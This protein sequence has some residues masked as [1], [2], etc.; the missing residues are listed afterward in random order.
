MKRPFLSMLVISLLLVFAAYAWAG[1]GD[2]DPTFGNQGLVIQND[3]RELDALVLQTDGKVVAVGTARS[4]G[5]ALARYNADGSLDATFGSGGVVI[6]PQIGAGLRLVLQPDGKLVAG[7]IAW[8]DSVTTNFALA[9]YNPDGSLD[10]TFGSGGI[11]ILPYST[12]GDF[13][14]ALALAPDGK[15]VAVGYSNILKQP[16]GKSPYY[17]EQILLARINA[18]GTLDQSFGTVGWVTKHP[19]DFDYGM[20]ATVQPDNKIIVGAFSCKDTELTYCTGLVLRYQ[21]DG[22]A[23]LSFGRRGVAEV[24]TGM[25][26]SS[27]G[28]V[29]L[30]ADGK[31]VGQ[32]GPAGPAGG[33]HVTRFNAD[34]SLD[35]TFGSGGV[36]VALKNFGAQ[37]MIARADGSLLLAGHSFPQVFDGSADFALMSFTEAGTV[38]PQFGNDGLAARH[39]SSYDM[40]NALVV[41]PDNKIVAAGLFTGS[42]GEGFIAVLAR[43]VDGKC[44][45]GTLEAGED[46]DDGNLTDGDGCDSNCTL[47]RC[48]NGIASSGE[49]C[50]DGNGQNADACKN[51]CTLNVC[52]DGVVRTG[53]EICDDGNAVDDD[54]CSNSC[55]RTRC[56]D[57][58]KDPSEECD[59]GNAVNGDGCD[60]NCLT[61]H[62]GNGR[63]EGGEQC[64][65][66]SASGD[67]NCA[68]DCHW[69]LQY[70]AVLRPVNPLTVKLGPGRDEITRYLT[71][72]LDAGGGHQAPDR[73]VAQLTASNGDCPAGTI[74]EST[75]PV[76][77][78]A[79]VARVFI[80]V[81][82]AA[83]PNATADTPQRC[84]LR[85]TARIYP[86][87]VYDPNPENNSV[88]V[89][90]NVLDLSHPQTAQSAS[91]SLQSVKPLRAQIARGVTTATKTVRLS[92]TTKAP[93]PTQTIT[94][95]VSDGTCPK[96]TVGQPAPSAFTLARK[97]R[98]VSLPLALSSTAF[99]SRSR[100]SPSR[101]TATVTATLGNG[102]AQTVQLVVD[103][104]DG[105]DL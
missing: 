83:F 7:G 26:G 14:T 95:T 24:P 50:D 3:L 86:E 81:K 11:A 34:G 17:K 89:E 87:D 77:F 84:T 63:V 98:T 1:A 72:L 9:R 10:A 18:D 101:C 66:G 85:L 61:E 62:C 8:T 52:G 74:D 46:C 73:H 53:V 45:N 104:T 82:R 55:Q 47:T 69:A 102:S 56:G 31:I 5:L 49:Q 67:A 64:D 100:T 23:D 13:F 35:T 4:D 51:D 19:A 25:F 33:V 48:G 76:T 43:F 88:S 94:I 29:R 32:G 75:D 59:D 20:S 65:S 103:V 70:D 58:V 22:Q 21:Q 68:A 27:M 97:R 54:G 16:P 41:Q 2:L 40:A 90:L 12:D 42:D 36:A 79:N 60:T 80:N 71:I 38:D 30:L 78:R 99:Q 37:T 28:D 15:L 91:F 105:N 93:D 6:T 44:S 92:V 96:G 39:L 57:G